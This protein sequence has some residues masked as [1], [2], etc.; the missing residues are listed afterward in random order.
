MGFFYIVHIHPIDGLTKIGITSSEIVDQRVYAYG[1]NTI[2]DYSFE[3][4][5]GETLY[6]LELEFK[7]IW[8]GISVSK[9]AIMAEWFYMFPEE[10]D[11]F[12]QLYLKEHNINHIRR[13]ENRKIKHGKWSDQRSVGTYFKMNHT[14]Q[15]IA[16]RDN[17]PS[18]AQP[19]K[20][21]KFQYENTMQ[22]ELFIFKETDAQIIE[23]KTEKKV[24][25]PIDFSDN[26]LFIFPPS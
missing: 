23:P 16:A 13:I 22:N 12:L 9:T 8:R 7:A 24:M 14:D 25:K 20:D 2:I 4:S 1:P 6:K 15:I 3:I 21:P 10:A 17:G 5:N 18:Q 26:S 11:H 19:Y